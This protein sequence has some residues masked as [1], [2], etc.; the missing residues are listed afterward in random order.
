M[1]LT[2]HLPRIF[3]AITIG[4]APFLTPVSAQTQQPANGVDQGGTTVNTDDGITVTLLEPPKAGDDRKRIFD[5]AQ[6]CLI[7]A[8][9]D[10]TARSITTATGVYAQ[11]IPTVHSQARNGPTTT[12]SVAV[13]KLF[14]DAHH[15][16]YWA[17]ATV[18]LET[19]AHHASGSSSRPP[20]FEGSAAMTRDT[21]NRALLV[22]RAYTGCMATLESR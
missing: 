2:S 1:S 12:F 3:A 14:V 15:S 5:A 18:T 22:A 4:V 16:P 10:T 8:V 9:A 19:K 20:G 21:L 6:G 11:G 13:G 17:R 7:K